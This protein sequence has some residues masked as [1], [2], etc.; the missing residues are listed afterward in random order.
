MHFRKSNLAASVMA[1]CLGNIDVKVLVLNSNSE[2]EFMSN[3]SDLERAQLT[4]I[5]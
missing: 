4:S 5:W 2:E 1:K 3:D